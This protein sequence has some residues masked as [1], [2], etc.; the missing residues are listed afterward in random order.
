MRSHLRF[1]RACFRCWPNSSSG[2]TTPSSARTWWTPYLWRRATTS[3]AADFPLEELG[4]ALHGCISS[5]WRYFYGLRVHL[6]VPRATEPVEFALAVGSGANVT[7]FKALGLY[8][9]EGS[10][11]YADKAYTDYDYQDL[12][13]E[14]GFHLK[15]R[16]RKNSKRAGQTRS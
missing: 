13:E 10:I 1:G 7:V 14:A 6:M 12:L 8:L 11:I 9:P 16:R 3:V 4:E 2:A 5:K 15:A